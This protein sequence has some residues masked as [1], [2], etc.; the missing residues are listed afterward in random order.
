MIVTTRI[1]NIDSEVAMGILLTFGLLW[2]F[3]YVVMTFGTDW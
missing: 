3:I 2:G 1:L